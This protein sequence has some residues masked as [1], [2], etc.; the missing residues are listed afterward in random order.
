MQ[1]AALPGPDT[2]P[3]FVRDLLN[4]RYMNGRPSNRLE[5]AGV[6]VHI[7]DGGVNGVRPWEPGEPA[8]TYLSASLLN[9]NKYPHGLYGNQAALVISPRSQLICCYPQDSGTKSWV[10]LRGCGPRQCTPGDAPFP[11]TSHDKGYPCAFP[12]E[13]LADCLAVF[14]NATVDESAYTEMV[15]SNAGPQHVIE[16]VVYPPGK[17]RGNGVPEALHA[18]LLAHFGL[19]A[20]QLPLLEFG[21]GLKGPGPLFKDAW[22]GG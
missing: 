5:D 15:V 2:P 10:R 12:R 3:G 14:D 20:N 18:S 17:N 22:V 11:R 1:I 13:M 16:A 6:L 19:T 9:A 8:R 4:A 7:L 21:P